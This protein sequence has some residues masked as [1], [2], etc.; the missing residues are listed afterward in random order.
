[1]LLIT[2]GIDETFYKSPNIHHNI[3]LITTE[4]LHRGK[5][6]VHLQFGKYFLNQLNNKLQYAYSKNI[7]L[8]DEQFFLV[9]EDG[10]QKPLIPKEFEQALKHFNPDET[11][12]VE[13]TLIDYCYVD[14]SGQ[15]E[16][17]KV[18]I[19][20]KKEESFAEIEFKSTTQYEN[21]IL[22]AWLTRL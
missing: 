5:T 13:E 8:Q 6:L 9:E 11:E 20:R 22:P 12:K 15:Q 3:A 2:Y 16:I 18:I 14:R 21:F 1:M 17:I 10:T 7:V 19:K 4:Y